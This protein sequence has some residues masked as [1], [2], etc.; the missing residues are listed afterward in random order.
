MKVKIKLEQTYNLKIAQ[1]EEQSQLRLLAIEN[2]LRQM[3]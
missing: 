1:L 3:Q 2:E